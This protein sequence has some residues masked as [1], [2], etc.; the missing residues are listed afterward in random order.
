VLLSVAAASAL[1]LGAGLVSCGAAKRTHPTTRPITAAEAALLAAMRMHNYRDSVA[2]LRGV[3]RSSG[4]DVRVAG[5]VDWHRPLIY[6]NSISTSPGPA[7]GLVQAV[8]GLVAV[9]TGRMATAVPRPGTP[10]LDPYPAPP[11]TAGGCG[12]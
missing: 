2:G 4:G 12:R 10:A 9:R 7:D 5:W 8:P 3:I 11:A 6:I 1:G